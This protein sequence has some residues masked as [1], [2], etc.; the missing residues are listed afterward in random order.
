MSVYWSVT[1]VSLMLLAVTMPTCL[2]CSTKAS[3]WSEGMR[4]VSERVRG[5][6]P[7]SA[8]CSLPH[9]SREVMNPPMD[10][11]SSSSAAMSS[12]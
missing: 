11:T 6:S 9:S 5:F 1:S 3:S 8:L 7:V 10:V 4:S 2:A 12:L